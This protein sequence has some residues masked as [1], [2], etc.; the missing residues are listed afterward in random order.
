MWYDGYAVDGCIDATDRIA[1]LM[2][3]RNNKE[4]FAEKR[5]A[6]RLK[7]LESYMLKGI[8]IVVEKYDQ[9]TEPVY[10]LYVGWHSR[11]TELEKAKPI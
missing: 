8:F 2:Q 6:M 1:V 11:K 3:A 7:E 4:L 9:I 10:K 5:N